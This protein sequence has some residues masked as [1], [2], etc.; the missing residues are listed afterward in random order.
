MP[1]LI[2]M[3]CHIIPGV[4]DGAGSK[5]DVSEML[6]MEYKSGVRKIILTPHYRKGMF[7]ADEQEVGNGLKDVRRII[8]ELGIEMEVFLGCE[9]H[10]NSDMI[11]EVSE[12][13]R[14]R[15]NGTR[16]VLVEFSSQH[17]F[18]KIRNWIY[19]L[20]KAGL[21]PIIAHVERCPA[22]TEKKELVEELVELGA[23]IQVDTGA[24]LGEDGWRVKT[25]S[26]KLLKEE[27]VHFIGS[28]AHDS[29]KRRPNLEECYSYVAKK[30]GDQYA[31]ELFFDNPRVLLK[32]EK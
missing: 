23:W 14:F 3:H 15:M 32:S 12:Y 6:L 21:E 26:R 7:E 17:N 20:V 25:I 28:D 13:E 8:Q 4:D 2:D 29:Q 30:V 19:E 1:E 16:Y 24:I 9:Y 22:V 10:A 27:L 18:A 31:Q 5:K 11:R